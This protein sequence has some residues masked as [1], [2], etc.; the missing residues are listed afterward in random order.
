MGLLSML[1]RRG[2]AAGGGAMRGAEDDAIRRGFVD[3]QSM[4]STFGQF[5]A[6]PFQ[7]AASGA[8]PMQA[9]SRGASG[10]DAMY[11]ADNQMAMRQAL[12][13]LRQQRKQAQDASELASIDEEING[14]LD[15]L[16]I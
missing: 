15:Q 9:P 5:Q 3:P 4:Q 7:R 8:P 2:G 12:T 6:Q 14:I 10:I 11:G 13:Q 1:A 16:G